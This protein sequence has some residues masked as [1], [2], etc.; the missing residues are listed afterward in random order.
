MSSAEVRLAKPIKLLTRTRSSML[1]DLVFTRA[2]T[3]SR[4]ISANHPPRS[5]YQ[6]I[7]ERFDW[8]SPLWLCYWCTATVFFF[9]G[10]PRTAVPVA[11]V[12]VLLKA[13]FVTGHRLPSL[14]RVSEK[15]PEARSDE[16]TATCGLVARKTM[17]LRIFL[18]A[19]L[20]H[21]LSSKRTIAAYRC[22]RFPFSG[23]R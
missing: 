3:F 12:L 6:N 16:L 22:G 14:K 1:F 7:C 17:P 18:R 9:R 8:W 2:I 21:L 23:C 11:L 4:L 5:R 10:C 19:N 13:D 20:Y 15:G